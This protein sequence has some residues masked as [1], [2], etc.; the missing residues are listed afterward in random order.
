MRALLVVIALGAA[1]C[2]A[3][4]AAEPPTKKIVVLPRAA[5]RVEEFTA[6]PGSVTFQAADPDAGFAL[7]STVTVVQWR[8]TNGKDK[9]GWVLLASANA[10]TFDGC[11]TI[12]VEAVTV[13]CTSATALG[14]AATG[15]CAAP[16]KLAHSPVQIA[17]G[18]QGDK[19]HQYIVTLTMRLEDK[20]SYIATAGATCGI[21]LTYSLNAR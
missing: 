3:V 17:G 16:V 12:P 19:D 2:A 10:A 14:S 1:A 11:P 8:I 13:T 18:Q 21:S 5:A 6:T 7:N 9:D 20:W 4:R 15:T